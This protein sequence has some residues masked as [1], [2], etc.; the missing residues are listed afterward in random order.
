MFDFRCFQHIR[1]LSR[2]NFKKPKAT[3]GPILKNYEKNNLFVQ[4][5]YRN[6]FFRI[7][8]RTYS[9]NFN[10]TGILLTYVVIYSFAQ[11]YLHTMQVCLSLHSLIFLKISKFISKNIVGGRFFSGSISISLVALKKLLTFSERIRSFT[12]KDN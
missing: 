5:C 3:P 9:L 11:V 2:T 8:K 10:V 4:S 7:N 1:N 6:F 12:V